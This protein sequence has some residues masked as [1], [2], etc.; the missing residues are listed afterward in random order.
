MSKIDTKFVTAGRKKEWTS[1][2]VN[3]PVYRASTCIF[4]TYQ[5]L[6]E[7]LKNPS[8]KKL[9]YGRK[10][11]PTQWAL[12]EAITELEGGEGT[13]LYPSGMAAIA[14]AVLALVKQGDHIL[15]PDSA[16]DPTR[17]FANT[18]LK[19]MG[20]ESSF[21]SPRAGAD[22][23]TYLQPNTSV[24]LME[25]PGSLTFEIQ[26]IP[27]IVSAA[28][29]RGIKTV[30]D[31]TWATPLFLNPLALGVDISVQA[32][33]KYICGHSDVM[34]GSATANKAT[35]PALQ[36]GSY[37]LGQTASADDAYLALRGLRT[38]GV[39]LRQ[40]QEG[41]L[42]VARWLES[43]DMVHA[44]NHPALES[45][46]DHALWKR[47]FKG[48][49]GL[50]SFVLKKGK[51]ADSGALVDNLKYFKMGFSWGGYESLILPSNPSNARSVN[52]WQ[53]PGPLYR[54]HIGLEDT[55]DLIRDLSE[56]LERFREQS[57]W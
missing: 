36:Y 13:I 50:F 25:S 49:T 28:K 42:T 20:V 54:V 22:I 3:P 11:T 6:Q 38:M 44:V 8:A 57:N 32:C 43:H 2:I 26:D 21:Y 56:G 30:V 24:I 41:A 17:H 47:D 12:T 39:R 51:E 37:E 29:E 14:G 10:G 35:F 1:G 55:D 45:S 23:E 27:A 19:K 52:T 5:D 40:H 34:L 15:I 16:Y 53:A 48:S 9:F 46:P 7:G 31:N 18:F 4:E 33:T